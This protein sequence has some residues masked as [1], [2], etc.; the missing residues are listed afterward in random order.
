MLPFLPCGRWQKSGPMSEALP[1]PS[2]LPLC[3]E[4]LRFEVQGKCIIDDVSLRVSAP[5]I[6]VILGPNGA[7]KSVLLRLL[8]GLLAPT[9]G[10]ITW[11]GG[12]P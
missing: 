6:S 8:H 9:R 4:N 10:H 2:L 11:G 5:G 7:G 1:A 12:R 3:V